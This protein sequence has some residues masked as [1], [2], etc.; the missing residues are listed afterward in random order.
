[1][2]KVTLRSEF[3]TKVGKVVLRTEFPVKVGKVAVRTIFPAKPAKSGLSWDFL[4]KQPHLA[5][6]TEFWA[7][8]GKAGATYPNVGC[9]K[10]RAQKAAEHRTTWYVA[11]NIAKIRLNIVNVATLNI[12]TKLMKDR[13]QFCKIM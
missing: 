2:G 11:N 9:S 12:T 7:K 3:W 5:L 1:M 13:H 8:L 6:R 10:Q 4:T